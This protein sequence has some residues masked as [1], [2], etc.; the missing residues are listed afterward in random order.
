MI[1]LSDYSIFSWTAGNRIGD[2]FYV[3]R[4]FSTVVFFLSSKALMEK[5]KQEKKYSYMKYAEVFIPGKQFFNFFETVIEKHSGSTLIHFFALKLKKSSGFIFHF[6]IKLQL[7]QIYFS[8][9]RMCLV[10]FLVFRGTLRRQVIYKRH[11]L[12]IIKYLRA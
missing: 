6:T 3:L 5:K 2:F 12:Y 1:N 7:E 10:A 4:E 8:K 11:V 9:I